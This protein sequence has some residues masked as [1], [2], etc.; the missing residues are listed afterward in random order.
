MSIDERSYT[1][2]DITR[3][4]DLLGACRRAG[5]VDME[6]LSTNLRLTLEYLD[7][8]RRQTLL[9]ERDGR[10]VGFALLWQGRYLGMLVDPGLR[11]ELERR[12]LA[13]AERHMTAAGKHSRLIV[14]C[15]DDD[16]LMIRFCDECG[17]VLEDE[18][19]RMGRALDDELPTVAI[20]PGFVIRPLLGSTELEEWLALYTEAFGPRPAKL[21]H[22]RTMRAD[23][24][25]NPELDLVAVTHAGHLAGMCYCSIASYEASI[26]TVIDG[27]TEPIAIGRDFQ[28]QG[29]GRAL[30]TTGLAAL[31]AHGAG[32]A[33]LTTEIDNVGAHRFYATLGYRELYRA[34]WYGR[35]LQNG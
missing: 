27:R 32:I 18:E 10:L 6:L 24:D 21:R 12:V 5:Y 13:W 22:W 2:S 33:T 35:D 23:P 3:V 28:R 15:R 11:G 17:F 14:L 16:P 19:L 29:L 4:F 20:P 25:H 1:D 26:D 30:V 8:D 31:R 7:F 9:L 34:R